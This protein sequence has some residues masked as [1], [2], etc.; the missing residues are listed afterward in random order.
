MWWW[1]V[2]LL[3]SFDVV[4]NADVNMYMQIRAWVLCG[5]HY[6]M[7]CMDF[8]WTPFPGAISGMAQWGMVI[9]A[10]IIFLL[11]AFVLLSW[12]LRRLLWRFNWR[13]HCQWTGLQG[14]R[15][16]PA[17]YLSHLSLLWTSTHR[18]L[19]GV[20]IN[21]H[22]V[23]CSSVVC[24]LDIIPLYIFELEIPFES[25]GSPACWLLGHCCGE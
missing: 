8:I 5:F 18:Q 2:G 11:L 17:V 20:A 19:G 4:K 10:G 23:K 16:G 13:C 3:P 15:P 12:T 21:R 9:R 1:I 7:F 6:L 25:R 14:L 24:C 22:G